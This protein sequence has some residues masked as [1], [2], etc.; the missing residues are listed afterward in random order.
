MKQLNSYKHILKVCGSHQV[1]AQ[2][3]LNGRG[4]TKKNGWTDVKLKPEFRAQL[5]EDL[6]DCMGGQEKT[7]RACRFT[8][9]RETPQHWWLGRAVVYEYKYRNPK[10]KRKTIHRI[11]ITYIA[12]QDQTWE[13]REIR[14]HL[15][16]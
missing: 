16:R 15:S 8:L 10:D 7:K 14:K 11:G 5:I 1:T 3:L 9:E 2:E 4:Y 13:N 6:L 12:G